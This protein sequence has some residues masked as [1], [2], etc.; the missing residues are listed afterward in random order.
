MKTTI[1][2]L[3]WFLFIVSNSIIVPIVIASQYGLN[4]SDSIEF[5][6]RT[7]F[8]LA[9]SGLLQV[10]VGHRYP[11]MEGPAGVWWGV[12]SLYAGLGVVLFG[13]QG[14]T[15]QV[16]QFSL[17]AS[18]V[19]GIFMSVFGLVDKL[20]RYFTPPVIGTYL[21]L[22]VA[23]LSGSFLKGMVGID[24]TDTNIKPLITVGSLIIVLL[25]F[26]VTSHRSLNKLNI[27][28]SIGL[29][30]GL[31]ALMGLTEPIHFE[32]HL[33]YLPELFVFGTPRVEWSMVITSLFVTFILITNML[34]S[35][36]VVESVLTQKGE[37]IEG[38]TVKR[39]GIASGV[40]QLLGGSFSAVGAVP[41][42]GSGGFIATTGIVQ[43]LPFIIASVLLLL[44][45]LFT[46]L[47][48]ILSS[49]P[50]AVGYAAI[51]PVFASMLTLGMKEFKQAKD[52]ED[53][54]KR[55]GIPLLAGI[56]VM[57]I[58]PNSFSNLSPILTTL[59][60][61][62]LVFGTMIAIGIEVVYSFRHRS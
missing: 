38:N 18:G 54:L 40:S 44:V 51:F 61:N 58:P 8:V 16:L 45:S 28:I 17:L 50:A 59:L 10:L 31:F 21:I 5:I 30:W 48:S 27:I 43:R 41:I 12:F 33:F 6:Q 13:S 36:K 37:K 15:L 57:F 39:A 29:G 60:S 55:A 56:G 14:E 11:I 3:Q 34:A 4:S 19:I 62:G 47:T 53:A 7:L 49:L 42:S 25:S 1:A 22:L 32:D 20:S 52:E 26:W 2:S 9:L 35:I 24:G 46:P 23:Q